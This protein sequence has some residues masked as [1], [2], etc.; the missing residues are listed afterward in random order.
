MEGRIDEAKYFVAKKGCEKGEGV[1]ADREVGYGS[2]Y[3]FC[4]GGMEPDCGLFVRSR[5]LFKKDMLKVLILV[6][7]FYEMRLMK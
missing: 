1:R 5:F 6:E 7:Y 2:I 3:G 4:I